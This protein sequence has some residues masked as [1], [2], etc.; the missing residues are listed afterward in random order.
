MEQI[1]L[2]G[3]EKIYQGKGEAVRALSSIDLA[4]EKG[5][6]IAIMGTS[7]SGKT[8]LLNILGLVDTLTGD[9]Y[10]L[11]GKDVSTLADSQRAKLRNESIGFVL[12]NFGLINQY[13]VEQNVAL[14][15]HYS[16]IPRKTWKIRAR[17]ALENVGLAEKRKRYPT[18]LSGGQ[19]QRLAIARAMITKGSLLLAD[20]PTGALDSRTSE[21]IMNLF[22]DIRK[23][24]KTVILVTHDIHIAQ[25]CDRVLTIEDGI[26]SK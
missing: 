23:Q 24:G 17:E 6:M 4:V 16:K 26:I 22:L 15:L 19:K 14:P 11:E 8:T 18:E 10:F 13:T 21:A 7:G 9:T 5:E 25:Y 2:I 1:K 3:I 12:Q 20:E